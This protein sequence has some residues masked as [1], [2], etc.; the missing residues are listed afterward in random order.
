MQHTSFASNQLYHLTNCHSTREAVRVHD[1][2][3]ADS[4]IAERHVC[5]RYYDATDALLAVP[6]AEFVTYFWSSGLSNQY[7][8]ELVIALISR[9]YHLLIVYS[10]ISAIAVVVVAMQAAVAQWLVHSDVAAVLVVAAVAVV[11][12]S[13]S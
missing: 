1:Q 6:A 4:C 13:S 5:L 8:D 9:H 10:V 7:L 12:C 11:Q 3:G 2:V